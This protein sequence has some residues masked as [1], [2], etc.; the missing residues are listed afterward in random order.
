MTNARAKALKIV[1]TMEKK[2]GDREIGQRFFEGSM[3][4]AGRGGV[5]GMLLG[6]LGGGYTAYKGAGGDLKNKIKHVLIGALGGGA[7]GGAYGAGLGGIAG[8]LGGA[9][10]G[11]R[12][13]RPTY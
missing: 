2:A 10:L 6:A 7:L 12:K 9:A 5:G 11:S 8:G 4:G 1:R 13:Q 3:G